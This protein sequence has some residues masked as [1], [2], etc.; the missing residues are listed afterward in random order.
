[1]I[2]RVDKIV[3]TDKLCMAINTGEFKDA[4][5]KIMIMIITSPTIVTNTK[6]LVV[7]M[8][9]VNNLKVSLK[10][11]LLEHSSVLLSS[12]MP[13]IPDETLPS[14]AAVWFIAVEN[15]LKP[16]ETAA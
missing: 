6:I 1:M 5:T 14:C 10:Y 12:D 3:I 11:I 15:A 2:S 4:S 8:T 16:S 9:R 7:V 13:K